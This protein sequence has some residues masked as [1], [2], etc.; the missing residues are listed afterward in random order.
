METLLTRTEAAKR[1]KITT[2]TLDE[3]RRGGYITY[4]QYKENGKVYFT[5]TALQEYLD[6]HTKK[7]KPTQ[8]L[9]TYR[10]RRS[11]F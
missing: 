3:L 11:G 4:I 2:A 1:L 6:K 9:L 7:A 5:E 10:R 8:S